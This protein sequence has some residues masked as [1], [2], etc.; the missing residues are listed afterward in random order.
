MGIALPALDVPRRTAVLDAVDSL[1]GQLNPGSQVLALVLKFR[2]GLMA[3]PQ[4]FYPVAGTDLPFLD[5]A[6][7][8]AWLEASP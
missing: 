4:N 3:Q 8:A 7:A 1:A 5:E 2:L 6:R